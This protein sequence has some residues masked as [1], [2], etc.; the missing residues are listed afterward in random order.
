LRRQSLRRSGHTLNEPANIFAIFSYLA[1]Y[2]ARFCIRQHSTGRLHALLDRI[3]AERPDLLAEAQIRAVADWD[4]P[5]A[6]DGSL[7]LAR[8]IDR[9][10]ALAFWRVEQSA[11]DEGWAESERT[12]LIAF[13]EMRPSA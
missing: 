12:F 7:H 9:L 1:R 8:L 2:D 3:A 10:I 4:D 6:T 11:Q 13:P 5:A